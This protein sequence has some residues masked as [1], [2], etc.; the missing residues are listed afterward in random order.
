MQIKVS[1]CNINVKERALELGCNVPTGLAIL[2]RNFETAK[3][4]DDL[5]YQ[6]DVATIRKLWRDAEV[7][8]TKIEK[9]GDEFPYI[10]E[11]SFECSWVGPTIFLGVQ[12]SPYLVTVALNVI[13]NYL[14]DFLKGLPKSKQNVQLHVVK[15]SARGEGRDYTEIDYTGPPDGIKELYETI[16]GSKL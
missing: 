10:I 1:K 4:K 9:E 12:L 15:Q 14:T 2:P 7:E 13:S 16:F 8:E 6:A 11:Q 5:V 3:S